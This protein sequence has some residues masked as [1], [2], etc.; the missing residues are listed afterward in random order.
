MLDP[1]ADKLLVATLFASLTVIG[2]IPVPLTLLIIAR[3]AA[4][5]A[6]GSYIRYVSL[7][8]PRTVSKYFDASLPTAKMQPTMLS[9]IN[10]TIQ[11]GLVGLTLAAPVFGF[12][13]HPALTALCWITAGSTISSFISYILAKDT[14]KILTKKARGR[15]RTRQ[16]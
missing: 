1:L 9:K 8:E 13:G 14:Y 3:D 10:T 6:A 5:V 11:L 12:T 4:L 16:S 7:P 15:I 2:H